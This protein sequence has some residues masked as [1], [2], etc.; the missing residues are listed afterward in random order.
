M[1]LKYVDNDSPLPAQ[2]LV[3]DIFKDIFC[4][5]YIH[6][7]IWTIISDVCRDLRKQGS[8]HP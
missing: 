7:I 3:I 1:K 5:Y 6:E 8:L 4:R 2:K